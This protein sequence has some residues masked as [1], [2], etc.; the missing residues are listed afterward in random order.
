[1]SKT[2][3]TPAAAVATHVTIT[4]EISVHQVSGRWN[5][6][7]G[8][9]NFNVTVPIAALSAVNT[10]ALIAPMVEEAKANLVTRVADRLAEEAKEAA[11]AAAKL[12]EEAGNHGT[13]EIYL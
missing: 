2:P 11:D 9:A 3:V 12:I 5:D 1:M 7:T 8:H 4:V 13:I 10:A 6:P